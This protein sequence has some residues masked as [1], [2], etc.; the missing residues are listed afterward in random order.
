MQML[1][2]RSSGRRRRDP[3]IALS[4]AS[5]P[6]QAR[7]PLDSKDGIFKFRFVSSPLKALFSLLR[8]WNPQR[9]LQR[10]EAPPKGKPFGTC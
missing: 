10:D 7:I 4:T 2:N 3:Q 6:P 1:E 8:R 5:P 9:A